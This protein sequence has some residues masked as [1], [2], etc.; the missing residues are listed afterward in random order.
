MGVVVVVQH[1]RGKRKNIADILT[2]CLDV[3][4]FDRTGIIRLC[5]TGFRVVAERI[6][7]ITLVS[8]HGN[9]GAVRQNIF[10]GEQAGIVGN[11]KQIEQSRQNVNITAI[12]IHIDRLHVWNITQK[13]IVIFFKCRVNVLSGKLVVLAFR[14]SIWIMVSG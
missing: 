10:S 4:I 1:L 9:M 8:Q 3:G 11:T 14:Q 6:R 12:G 7:Q 13:R 2:V 5:G